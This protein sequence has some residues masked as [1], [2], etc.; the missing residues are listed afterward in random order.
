MGKRLDKKKK[1]IRGAAVFVALAMIAVLVRSI[2]RKRIP[3]I[4]YC[5][6]HERDQQRIDYLNNKMVAI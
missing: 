1:M 4:T 2:I 6:M 5:P 3:R